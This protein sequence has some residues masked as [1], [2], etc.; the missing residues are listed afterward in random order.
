MRSVIIDKSLPTPAYLQLKQQL[1]LSINEG[2]LRPGHA[3]PSERQLADSLGLSRMTVRHA[4]EALVADGLVE[5]RQGSGT[6]VRAKPLEQTIDRLAGFTDE[7]RQLGLEA[8]SRQ[9]SVELQPAGSKV[10]DALGISQGERV[11]VI[12]RL[13]TA[14]DQA[15]AIQIAHLAPDI[16]GLSLEALASLGSLY[17]AIKQQFGRTPARA[18]Q[19][20]GARLPTAAEVEL[21]GI[22]RENPVLSL[23]RTSFDTEDVPLEFVRSAYRGDLYRLALDLRS[24]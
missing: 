3:L 16:S 17:A 2:S 15:V 18:R 13:R 7:M 22:P 21:L 4:F 24:P 5:Q 23:E 12:T 11:L 10:A 14:G 1:A 9:L 6:Y 8:G 19:T 20:I